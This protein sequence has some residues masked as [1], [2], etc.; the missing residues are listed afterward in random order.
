MWPH[1]GTC[2]L[3]GHVCDV[4]LCVNDDSIRRLNTISLLPSNG[5]LLVGP[6]SSVCDRTAASG[7]GVV[8]SGHT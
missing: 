7:V 2:N 6:E 4:L 3:A 8:I 5:A 1:A